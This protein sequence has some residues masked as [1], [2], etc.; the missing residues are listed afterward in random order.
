VNPN[1]S[2]KR[3]KKS[4]EGGGRCGN[5]R[6]RKFAQNKVRNVGRKRSKR[7]QRPR[8]RHNT[9]IRRGERLVQQAVLWFGGGEVSFKEEKMKRENGEKKAID[10]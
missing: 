7:S 8:G 6:K 10:A 3:Q 2:G 1:I 9:P 4:G 5:Q